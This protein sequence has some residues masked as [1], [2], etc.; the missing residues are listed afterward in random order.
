MGTPPPLLAPDVEDLGIYFYTPLLT[1]T[2]IDTRDP[3]VSDTQDT[4]NGF[5]TIES[6]GMNRIDL[7]SY[8][9]SFLLHAYSPVEAEAADLSRNIM[10]YGTAVQNLS[11]MGWLIMGLV[12]AVGGAKLPNPDVDLPRYRS[13]LT[14]RV[15]G[16]PIGGS[17]VY[18][19]PITG[20]TGANG[21]FVYGEV[22]HGN[23]IDEVFSLTS[24]FVLN[25]VIVYVNGIRQLRGTDYNEL[26][27]GR[28]GFTTPPGSLDIVVV[29]YQ[30]AS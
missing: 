25:T 16:R 23:G 3:D 4:I 21:V 20:G 30:L 15:Q 24:A 14:W 11:V 13:A 9:V 22:L 10:A 28:I 6:A 2:L 8:H 29:D 18:T 26:S 1:P 12:S 27:G 17:G 7:A 19:P 5:V